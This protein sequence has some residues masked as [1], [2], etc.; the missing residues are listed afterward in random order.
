MPHLQNGVRGGTHA[1]ARTIH[2]LGVSDDISTNPA[3]V[4]GGL[5]PGVTPLQWTY[6][7]SSIA[8]DGVRVSGTLSPEPGDSPV[9]YTAVKDENGNYIKDGENDKIKTREVPAP[10]AQEAKSIL[11]N[12]VTGGTGVRANIGDPGQ[13]GKT[14]TTENNGD[15]WF[16]GSAPSLDVT[17]CVWVGH[18]DSNTPMETEYGGAPVDGGTFPALIWAGVM[19]A[20]EQIRADRGANRRLRRRQRRHHLHAADHGTC[21]EQ[22]RPRARP[23][24]RRLPRR[25]HP[26]HLPPARPPRP[27]LLPRPRPRPRRAVVQPGA[28]AAAPPRAESA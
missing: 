9:A 10:T 23:L 7:Y 6:A 17:A 3:M 20:W 8:N 27:P 12:V 22:P 28:R 11:H 19:T 16:C 18:A 15:A 26:R 14:G 24:P 1:I 25:P 2:E 13:W 5:D 21:A 4:L